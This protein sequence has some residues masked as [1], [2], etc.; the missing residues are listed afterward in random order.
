MFGSDPGF[1]SLRSLHPGLYRF[2]AVGDGGRVNASL[3]ATGGKGKYVAVGN[4][5]E[6]KYVGLGG[7]ADSLRITGLA[8]GFVRPLLRPRGRDAH[9]SSQAI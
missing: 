9:G 6:G 8:A 7:G 3:L 1:H 2:V 4:G 5:G